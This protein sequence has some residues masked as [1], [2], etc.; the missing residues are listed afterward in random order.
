[1]TQAQLAGHVS[2]STLRDRGQATGRAEPLRILIAGQAGA[3]KSSLVN[4]LSQD[5]RAVVDA[6]GG[7]RDF[8]A[9]EVEL[10]GPQPARW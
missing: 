1:M 8:Q 3:G 7:T 10:E 6:P 2:A 5:V 9:Y 4:A